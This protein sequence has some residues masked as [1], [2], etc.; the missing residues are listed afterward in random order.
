[1]K[2]DFYTDWRNSM[3]EIRYKIFDTVVMSLVGIGY[4]M[5]AIVLVYM[6][7]DG[8]PPDSPFWTFVDWIKS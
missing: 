3:K 1:M 2:C 5:C 6:M 4:I 8:I 7:Y